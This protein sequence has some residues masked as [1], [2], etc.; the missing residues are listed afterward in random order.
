MEGV[1]RVKVGMR[2][3]RKNGELTGVIAHFW[4]WKRWVVYWDNGTHEVIDEE[5]LEK[6]DDVPNTGKVVNSGN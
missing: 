3:R 1:V 5:R 2:V 6:V 4:H